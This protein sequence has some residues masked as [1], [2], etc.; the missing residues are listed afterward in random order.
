MIFAMI[1]FAGAAGCDEDLDYYDHVF[2]G[3][4]SALRSASY[5]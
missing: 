2:Y 1:I 5:G 3:P 4:W